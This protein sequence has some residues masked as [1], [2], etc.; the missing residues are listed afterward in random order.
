M[1]SKHV[2]TLSTSSQPGLDI[3][4]AWGVPRRGAEAQGS[5]PRG[6]DGPEK[7]TPDGSSLPQHDTL[8]CPST[9]NEEVA[10]RHSFLSLELL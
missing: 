7:G 3:S 8:S 5:V 1:L 6:T 4:P 9:L 2:N 10:Y